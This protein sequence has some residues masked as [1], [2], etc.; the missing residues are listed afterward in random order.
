MGIVTVLVLLGAVVIRAV[1][2]LVTRR[3]NAGQEE[4]GS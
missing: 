2:A 1:M 3:R 4:E